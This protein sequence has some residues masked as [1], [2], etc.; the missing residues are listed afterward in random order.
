MDTESQAS[1]FGELSLSRAS[2]IGWLG[3]FKYSSICNG[4]VGGV[5]PVFYQAFVF[6]DQENRPLPVPTATEDSHGNYD[7]LLSLVVASAAV[8]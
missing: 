8:S 5:K 1:S 6:Q 2:K 3:S 4:M 7:D